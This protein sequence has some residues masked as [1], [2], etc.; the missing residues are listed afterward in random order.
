MENC[1]NDVKSACFR[2]VKRSNSVIFEDIDMK[3][4]TRVHQTKLFNIYSVFF[5]NF[6]NVLE[7]F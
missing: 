2:H 5:E 1:R 4:C 6:E 7:I 3:F